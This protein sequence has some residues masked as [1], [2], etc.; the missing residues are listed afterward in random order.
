MKKI[1][2]LFSLA[3]VML[4]A[5]TP[6]AYKKN[7]DGVLIHVKDTAG[8][9]YIK[10]QVVSDEIIHVTA[11]PTGNFSTEKSLMV[12]D[13]PMTK[14]EWTLKDED[15]ILILSTSKLQV[16][17][18]LQRGEISYFDAHGKSMLTEVSGGG[19][20]FEPITINGKSYYTIQQVFESPDDEAFYGLGAHQ[21]DIMNYKGKDVD[22]Y[23][24]N[25]VDIIPFLVSSR[26]Y[27]ILWDNY[28]R[29]KFGDPRDYVD[30]N[31]L[32]LYDENGVEGGLTAVYAD[33]K[34]D[35]KIFLSRSE[36][37]IR[38]E[39]LND[40]KTIPAE[41][42]MG[43]GKVTWNGFIGS[44]K[45]GIHKFYAYSAGYMKLWFDGK[46][47]LDTWR[48]SWN[49]WSHLLDLQLEAGK[50]YPLRIE[51]IPDGGESYIALKY[52]SPYDPVKQNQLSLWSEVADQ[53]DYYFVSGENIDE[54]IA[55]Y[56]QLT[57][58]CPIMPKWAMGFWQSRERYVTQD[59]LLGVVKEFRTKHIPLDNIVLDW[60]YWPEDKWGDHN[61]DSARFPDPK[62]MIDELHKDLHTQIMISVWPKLY[63]GTENYNYMSSKGW[64]YTRNVENQQKDWVGKGY[65]STFY[66]VFNPDARKYFWDQM[67]KKLFSIG[68][69]AWWMDATEPDILSNTSIEQ[70]KELMKPMYV[71]SPAK[72][73]NA[74]SLENSRAVYEGQRSV[75]PDQRVFILT[76]SAYAGQ[77]RYA[78]ATWSGDV[79]CRWYDLKAQIA[80][81]LNFC[82]SGIPYWT[83][84]IGG[85]SLEGR[86]YHPEGQDLD[87]WRELNTRWYQFGVFCP[88]FRVHGQY[89]YREVFNMAPEDN[90]TYKSMVYYDKLR[91]RLMPYIYTLAG[92][93]YHTDYTIMRALVM[94][95]PNDIH[96]RAI[97]DQ[98]MFGPSIM[99]C[100]VYEFKARNRQ[101]YL[102]EGCGWY[103]FYTGKYYDGG[104]T[105]LADAP[106]EKVPLFVKE[107]SVIPVGPEIEYALQ[108][109]DN[110]ITLWIYEGKDAQ[111]TLYEDENVNYNYEKGAF[112]ITSFTYSE[113]EK[114]LTVGKRE[115]EFEGLPL[116][117]KIHVISI[118]KIKATAFN[119]AMAP[120]IS[121]EFTGTEQVLELK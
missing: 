31:T 58:K 91:Y 111:F 45:S 83:S 55:G 23:Q 56:R 25:I 61:F 73:Y 15:S 42:K 106:L 85:F 4:Y 28:S 50:K 69:D 92:N 89:P 117:R 62:A 74:Y 82:I 100:P 110:D 87:E 121:T 46:L 5:C 77:Q 9:T 8:T 38:Y 37:I 41:F 27:G 52:K 17:I 44:D 47:L 13:Q 119:A 76:R 11:N 79:A 65:V 70:R 1:V 86:F 115:G 16:R 72:Y 40:L 95:F 68:I 78:S 109:S 57:G 63:V 97:G 67:N 19:K 60:F 120:E 64:V 66:D 90:P 94:D 30:I 104:Q 2:Y 20:S 22:L 71:G 81:G 59:E 53:I 18:S 116:S 88:L 21:H 102:P 75:K 112:A 101:V 36:N 49:P 93:T 99:V 108:P 103:D 105:I 51:W 48:Q 113:A 6:N 84:D 26:N 118:N 34:N 10:V 12:V 39:Y 29:S 107:G 80:A 24:H 33:K 54:I 96:V 35:T 98:F 114:R 32:K 3:L 7:D 14:A 43:E